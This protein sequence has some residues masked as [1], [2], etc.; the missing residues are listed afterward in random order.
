MAIG[1][2]DLD[3]ISQK[4]YTLSPSLCFLISGI[5]LIEVDSPGSSIM[6]ATIQLSDF[7]NEIILKK[8]IY[9]TFFDNPNVIITLPIEKIVMKTFQSKLYNYNVFN[10]INFLFY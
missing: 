2:Y 10:R 4:A 3:L 1:S 6:K 5:N 8:G 7:I 9:I